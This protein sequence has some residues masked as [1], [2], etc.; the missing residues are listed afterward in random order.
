MRVDLRGPVDP[1]RLPRPVRLLAYAARPQWHRT[2]RALIDLRL[3]RAVSLRR[4]VPISSQY[5]LDRGT[6]ID[7]VFIHDFIA[8]YAADI[9]GS[10]LEVADST[11][12]NRFGGDA[13][14]E[15]DVVDIN[16]ANPHAT[17]IADLAE[18]DSLPSG[19]YDCFILTQTLQYA[20]DLDAAMRNCWRSL[21]PGGTLLITLPAVG[22]IEYGLADGDR[23]RLT[24]PGLEQVIT[25]N[26]P[27]AK[28][29]VRGYGN[30][31]T[32]AASL[33]GLAAEDLEHD[34]LWYQ[35]R[36]YPLVSCAR[37]EHAN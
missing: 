11:L 19:R 24:P 30:V 31:L 37:V 15:R 32:C 6:P 25:D 5:G 34:R 2:R 28:V 8:K 9:R 13:V 23:W 20:S 12:T 7:R 33:Y 17:V 22:R 26:C 29:E 4:S 14:R 35:D 27:D 16:A 1:E 36:L 21:A 10:V 3:R 18:P